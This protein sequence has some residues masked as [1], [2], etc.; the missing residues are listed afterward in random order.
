MFIFTTRH[1][2]FNKALGSECDY[3]TPKSYTMQGIDEVLLVLEEKDYLL[4]IN[5]GK[6]L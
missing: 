6:K 2:L 3:G 1:N 4:K 5:V